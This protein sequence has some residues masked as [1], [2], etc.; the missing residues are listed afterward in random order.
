[1][2]KVIKVASPYSTVIYVMKGG[3]PKGKWSGKREVTFTQTKIFLRYLTLV[4]NRY[5]LHL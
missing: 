2:K 4:T 1:M 3:N 5:K